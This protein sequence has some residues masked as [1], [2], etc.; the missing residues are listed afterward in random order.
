MIICPF[1]KIISDKSDYVYESDNFLV[2]KDINP[3]QKLH[4]LLITKR[5][6]ELFQDL[7][8]NQWLNIFTVLHILL[9]KYN[10]KHY[11]LIHNNGDL[12]G[13]EVKHIHYHF[14]SNE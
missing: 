11:T 12:A 2:I 9:E 6:M 5:H 10:L 4:L 13:Q 8:R 3:K 1:C 14:L 7:Q